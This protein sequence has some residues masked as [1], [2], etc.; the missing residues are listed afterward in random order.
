MTGDYELVFNVVIKPEKFIVC[1]NKD[2]LVSV[3]ELTQN[4]QNEM[5]KDYSCS[6]CYLFHKKWGKMVLS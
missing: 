2:S 5:F 3:P 4:K 6:C 1:D